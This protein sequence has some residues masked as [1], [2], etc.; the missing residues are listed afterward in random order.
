MK[1]RMGTHARGVSVSLFQV[2]MWKQMTSSSNT[3]ASDGK[4]IYIEQPWKIR[5]RCC[6]RQTESRSKYISSCCCCHYKKGCERF[7]HEISSVWLMHCWVELSSW[8]SKKM[9]TYDLWLKCY[10]TGEM[11]E[12][13]IISERAEW[14]ELIK[15]LLYTKYWKVCLM[16]GVIGESK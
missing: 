9:C 8:C 16:V 7:A 13:Y 2:I 12:H 4:S 11:T 1:A 15:A 10:E 5:R 3:V 6:S 14:T